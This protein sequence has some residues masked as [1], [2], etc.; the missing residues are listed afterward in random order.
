MTLKA[1]FFRPVF[2]SQMRTRTPCSRSALARSSMSASSS[3]GEVAASPTNMAAARVTAMPVRSLPD[4]QK[5]QSAPRTARA[6]R[7]A[8]TNTSQCFS[9]VFESRDAVSLS[10]A[11][12]R[13]LSALA[14]ARG[15]SAAAAYAA[16]PSRAA[17]F[18][19]F[20]IS[21]ASG[22]AAASSVSSKASS[23]GGATAR[24]RRV[25]DS[26]TAFLEFASDCFASRPCEK[27]NGRRSRRAPPRPSASTSPT[28][29]SSVST[30]AAA[31]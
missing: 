5:T 4:L 15:S 24:P 6:A 19:A 10:T 20:W 30:R 18:S 1:Y 13:Y 28:G 31:S 14:A 2:F 26:W 12:E 8:S 16:K 11:L 3:S 23:A 25:S 21:R 29:T 22:A 27:R 17:T 7:S 9:K